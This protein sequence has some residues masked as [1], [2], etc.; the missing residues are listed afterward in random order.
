[1]PEVCVHR[2][3]PCRVLEYL[4][5]EHRI[6]RKYITY[7]GKNYDFGIV[8]MINVKRSLGMNTGEEFR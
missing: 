4:R 6:M 8:Y 5:E 1:M 3:I 2:R 7:A